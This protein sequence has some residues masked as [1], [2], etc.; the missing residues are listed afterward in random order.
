MRWTRY[1]RPS[2][3]AS[4][5]TDSAPATPFSIGGS[6]PCLDVLLAQQR[7]WDRTTW[8][9]AA[10]PAQAVGPY[11]LPL[12]HALTGEPRR[13]F[14]GRQA[15]DSPS[16]QTV[17]ESSCRSPRANHRSPMQPAT[18]IAIS[19]MQVDHRREP[20]EPPLRHPHQRRPPLPRCGCPMRLSPVPTSPLMQPLIIAP[21][22]SRANFSSFSHQRR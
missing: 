11:A 7:I 16:L 18:S 14:P 12:R 20:E 5:P 15:T 6:P 13:S 17:C 10:S 22:P 2:T 3:S 1:T 21:T 9:Y 19:R 8:S 4:R